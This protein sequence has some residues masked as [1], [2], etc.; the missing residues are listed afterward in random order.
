MTTGGRSAND[1]RRGVFGGADVAWRKGR[2]E[3][4]LAMLTNGGKAWGL[5]ASAM[6][7]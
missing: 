3:I 5:I 7:R 2:N 4:V 1:T 6:A